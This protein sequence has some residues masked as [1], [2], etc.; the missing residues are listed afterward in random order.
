MFSENVSNRAQ[1][2]VKNRHLLASSYYQMWAIILK[3]LLSF[4]CTKKTPKNV[5]YWR[6]PT[7]ILKCEKV[8]KRPDEATISFA[9]LHI[10][11]HKITFFPKKWLNFALSFDQ[12]VSIRN[13]IVVILDAKN[14]FYLFLFSVTVFDFCENTFVYV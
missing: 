4:S 13:F 6:H 5:I 12:K 3:V 7:P 10:F 11:T 8:T 1:K 2:N 14:T 9:N